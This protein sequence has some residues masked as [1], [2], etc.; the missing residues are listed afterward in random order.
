LA[1]DYD[2]WKNQEPNFEQ[3]P[4]G[5][6]LRLQLAKQAVI[7]LEHAQNSEDETR[8]I[9]AALRVAPALPVTDISRVTEEILRDEYVANQ[10]LGRTNDVE[11]SLSIGA[12][13]RRFTN[14]E[15]GVFKL[16]GN[17]LEKAEKQLDLAEIVTA[18]LKS[19]ID[20]IAKANDRVNVDLR[21][22]SNQ[23]RLVAELDSLADV[24]IPAWLREYVSSLDVVTR[25]YS[26]VSV[27]LARL[28]VEQGGQITEQVRLEWLSHLLNRWD[29]QTNEALSPPPQSE[30]K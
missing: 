2:R 9:D 28:G 29:Q 23:K 5:M 4:A 10:Q 14:A 1:S 12:I 25:Q 19:T 7:Q 22:L 15:N 6:L 11:V 13:C 17:D 21:V 26:Y 30:H 3:S 16:M 8:R 27:W 24:Q 18:A 20:T